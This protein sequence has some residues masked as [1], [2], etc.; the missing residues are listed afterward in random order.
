M[1]TVS[2]DIQELIE[3][4][5]IPHNKEQQC[6][7]HD[8]QRKGV[9]TMFCKT[10]PIPDVE[11]EIEAWTDVL[12]TIPLPEEHQKAIQQNL[13]SLEERRDFLNSI[14]DTNTQ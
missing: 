12:K 6:M 8:I 7:S 5:I 14:S 11:E 13:R 2:E 1:N 3:D 4:G 10:T 9:I